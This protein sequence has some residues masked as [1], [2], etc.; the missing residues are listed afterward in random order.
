LLIGT[1]IGL[2]RYE[3]GKITWLAREP[4]L[5]LPDVRTVIEA[6]DGTLWFGMSGGGLGRLQQGVLRQ[7][8]RSD[9]LSSD[10]VQCLHLASDGT[11]WI[12]TFNGLNRLKDGRFVAIT[13]K[14]GL[15]ERHHLRH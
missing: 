14:Q 12:G 10:F 5:H 13:K 11:L 2:M 8:R 7:F 15:P 6:P 1:G 4:E 3:P 9:G